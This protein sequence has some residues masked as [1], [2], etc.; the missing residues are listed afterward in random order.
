MPPQITSCQRH[1][2]D[3]HRARQYHRHRIRAAYREGISLVLSRLTIDIELLF[4]C[5]SDISYETWFESVA[6]FFQERGFEM[7]DAE[8]GATRYAAH[9]TWMASQ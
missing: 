9:S 1:L 2:I 3:S 8:T 4:N 6:G 7:T 5:Q